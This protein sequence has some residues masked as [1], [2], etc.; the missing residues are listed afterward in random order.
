MLFMFFSVCK[1]S[2]CWKRTSRSA[3]GDGS[4]C[5]SCTKL[6]CMHATIGESPWMRAKDYSFSQVL[7]L[8]LYFSQCQLNLSNIFLQN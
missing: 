2:P 6:S 1:Q 3:A 7:Y 8:I 4:W 5:T